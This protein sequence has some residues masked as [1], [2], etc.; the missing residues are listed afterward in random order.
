MFT[1]FT[2]ITALVT[3]FSDDGSVDFPKLDELIERQIAGGVDGIVVCA[4]TGESPTLTKKEKLAVLRRAV[5]RAKRKMHVIACTGSNDTATTVEMTKAAKDLRADA[6]LV[7][8][9]YY[10]K[11]TQEG[12]LRHYEAA[13]NAAAGMPVILYNVPGRTG[14]TLAPETVARLMKLDNIVAIKEAGGSVEQVSMILSVCEIIVLSGD[15]ALTLPMLAVGAKGVISVAA[16]IVPKDV[17]EMVSSFEQGQL[18]RARE[19]HFKLFSLCKTLFVETNPIPVKTALKRLGI[20]N[21]KLRLPLCEMSAHNE[22][23]LVSVLKNYG[24]DVK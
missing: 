1:G 13:A 8:T 9:P 17:V 6:T 5:R 15:D 3:P 7:V 18:D 23:K 12:L 11:P 10:N 14:V 4:T 19:I 2:S 24:L 22:A 20:L 16:N 21:G